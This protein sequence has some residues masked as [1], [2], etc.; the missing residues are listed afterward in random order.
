M[1]MSSTAARRRAAPRRG[2]A[3][4]ARRNSS[5][6][7]SSAPRRRAPRSSR[8]TRTNASPTTT[9]S[10]TS[11]SAPSIAQV[12][13][14][15]A[16]GSPEMVAD[17]G[18][19]RR[20]LCSPDAAPTCRTRRR[21][22]GDVEIVTWCDGRAVDHGRSASREERV[23]GHHQCV[24]P[25]CAKHLPAYPSI[26]LEWRAGLGGLTLAV[27]RDAHAPERGLEVLA[28]SLR[29]VAPAAS[30]SVRVNAVPSPGGSGAGRR[31][32]RRSSFAAGRRRV[33][34][35][36]LV[37]NPGARPAGGGGELAARP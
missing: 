9:S 2:P 26:L 18:E 25:R 5:I 29:G 4:T 3:F 31:G 28:R 11:S 16:S 8:G 35:C 14:G 20:H 15:L 37:E 6:D 36:E 12:D 23:A 7:A 13:A 34:A 30:A 1:R 32:I 19:V 21:E 27:E 22:D 10:R 33:G 24:G 17:G